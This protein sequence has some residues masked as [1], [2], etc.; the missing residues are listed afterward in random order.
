[1]HVLNKTKLLILN[2]TFTNLKT[3][4][5]TRIR[6]CSMINKDIFSNTTEKWLPVIRSQLNLSIVLIFT[7]VLSYNS[8]KPR[9]ISKPSSNVRHLIIK[10]DQ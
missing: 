10:H 2:A 9:T 4:V 6:N 5:F 1:M 7:I 8:L 3:V